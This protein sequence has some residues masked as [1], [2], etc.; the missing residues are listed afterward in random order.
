MLEKQVKNVMGWFICKDNLF[1][2]SLRGK[3][4][5]YTMQMM[6]LIRSKKLFVVEEFFLFLMMLM[7]Q[8]K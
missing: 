1:R 4:I 6:E 2:I 8:K 7:I 5:K 3:H